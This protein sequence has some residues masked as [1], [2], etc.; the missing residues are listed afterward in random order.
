MMFIKFFFYIFIFYVMNSLFYIFLESKYINVYNKDRLRYIAKNIVK[1]IILFIL[2]LYTI[3]VNNWSNEN[4][5]NYGITY[6]S[7]DILSLIMYHD[8]LSITTKLHHSA[9]L[10]LS[11]L[12]LYNNYE[13]YNVW[14][15][16][17]LYCLL[18]AS[19]FYINL[20]L[21]LRFLI[22]RTL[23]TII[24]K[25]LFFCYLITCFI[26]WLYQIYNIYYF[27]NIYYFS[28]ILFIVYDDIVL[29]KFLYNY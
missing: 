6:A 10:V 24:S 2:F 19:T 8:I 28:L 29:L 9:V 15:G 21:G 4:I 1:S 26:N 7:H 13:I 25:K 3:I 22:N 17:V 5:Y 12:N 20:F 23:S 11:I 14:H 27:F 18:S 16:L